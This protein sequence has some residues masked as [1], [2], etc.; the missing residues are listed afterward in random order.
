MNRHGMGVTD[1]SPRNT[2]V[3]QWISIATF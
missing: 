2:I 1:I 3:M